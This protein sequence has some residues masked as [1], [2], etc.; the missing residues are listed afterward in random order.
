MSRRLKIGCIVVAVVTVAG[1]AI[2]MK[3]IKARD[4][5]VEVEQVAYADIDQTVTAVPV[6]GQPA[7]I[8]KP[9]EVKVIPKIGG[10]VMQL[11]VE[12]GDRVTAG[13]AIAYLDARE[14]RASL[15]QAQETAASARARVAQAAADAGAAPVRADTAVTEAR[16]AFEQAK[17]KYSTAL[18]GARSEEIERARQAVRQAEEDVKDTDASLAT[19]RRGARS[20]EIASG[21]AALRQAEADLQ[22]SEASLSLLQAGSRP[23]EIAQAEATLRDCES[24]CVLR[25]QELESDRSLAEKGYV[26]RNQ[27]QAALSAYDTACARCDT[28]RQQLAVAKQP[29]RTQELDQAQAAVRR[30]QEGVKRAK[31]DLA[32]LRSR[33]TPEDLA[34]AEARRASASSRL[35]AARAALRLSENQ[36]TPEDLRVAAAAVSQSQASARRAEVDRVSIQQ[37]AL[38]VQALGADLRRSEAALQQAAERAGYTAISAPINGIVTRVNCKRGEY[39]QG[40][41][42]PLPSAEMAMLVITT[43]DRVW[44]ECNIDESDVNDV[45]VGQTANV[46]LG[47]GREIKARVHQISPSVRQSQGDVRT[48]AVKLAVEGDTSKLHSGM[49]VDVDIVTKSIKQALSVPSFAIFDGKDNKY[50]VYVLEDGK[51]KKRGV[52]KGTAGRDRTEITKGVKAGETVITSLEAKGL[53]EGKQVKIAV[54]KPDDKD[55]KDPAPGGSTPAKAPSDAK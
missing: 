37:R 44:I 32:L 50:Y 28:A 39:V 51:A 30:S 47:E 4:V 18:R 7:G 23:E 49:S 22:S 53:V 31:S 42:I 27:L 35:T 11:L 54:K 8:V 6:A 13:Q 33:T 17:A 55:K 52:T 2:P 9:D 38:D 25:T 34:S 29:H 26:S 12:E 1:I 45:A 15:R 10:E 40:G 19:V 5:E 24:Q 21:E 14:V 46:L 36:T 48:F 41:A 43:T 20:E 3:L 16:A